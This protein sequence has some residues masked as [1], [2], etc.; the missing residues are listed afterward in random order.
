MANMPN[1][2]KLLAAGPTAGSGGSLVGV[3]YGR[4]GL[5]RPDRAGTAA[6]GAVQQVQDLVPWRPDAAAPRVLPY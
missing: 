3:I 4:E 1:R 2:A 6:C 5:D